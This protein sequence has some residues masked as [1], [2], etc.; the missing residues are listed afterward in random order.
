MKTVNRTI[1]I[2]KVRK[3]TAFTFDG[4]SS[5]KKGRIIIKTC[6]Y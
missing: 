6:N 5:W 2:G 3:V 4:F 1:F